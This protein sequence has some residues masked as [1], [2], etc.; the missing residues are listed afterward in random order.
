ML[1]MFSAT[2]FNLDLLFCLEIMSEF[3]TSSLWMSNCIFLFISASFYSVV[4]LLLTSRDKLILIDLP[5]PFEM[6]LL[7]AKERILCINKTI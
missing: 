1:I 4:Y 7:H 2:S 3:V 6:S 5:F